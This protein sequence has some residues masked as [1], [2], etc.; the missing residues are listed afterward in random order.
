M[1]LKKRLKEKLEKEGRTKIWFISNYL[2]SFH[3]STANNQILG[4]NE[5]SNEVREA[6]EK[7]LGEW[8]KRRH[9]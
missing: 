4:I 7:Y 6:I 2:P 8:W 5:M 3:Y 1:D 9:S